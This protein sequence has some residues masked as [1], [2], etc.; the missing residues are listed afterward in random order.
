[1]HLNPHAKCRSSKFNLKLF[2]K[3]KTG[4]TYNLETLVF[5]EHKWPPFFAMYSLMV[6]LIEKLIREMNLD[7][8]RVIEF[9]FST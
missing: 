1:M 8:Y 9:I 3:R 7:I 6:I 5:P 2:K 4:V